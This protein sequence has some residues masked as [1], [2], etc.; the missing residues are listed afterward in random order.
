MNAKIWT[1]SFSYDQ[2]MKKPFT[3]SKATKTFI[4]YKNATM[5]ILWGTF[6][7]EN[8]VLFYSYKET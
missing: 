2:T 5:P 8:G 4:I 3:Y 1:K 6:L 7:S